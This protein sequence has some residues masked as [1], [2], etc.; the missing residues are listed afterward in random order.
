MRPAE[1][2]K[3]AQSRRREVDHLRPQG[4]TGR[5]GLAFERK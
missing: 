1:E 4:K 5:S 3:E 2:E